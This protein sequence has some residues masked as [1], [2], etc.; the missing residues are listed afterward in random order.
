MA[1]M[2][3]LLRL[4]LCLGLILN[5]SVYAAASTQMQ[6]N[7]LHTAVAAA[8]AAAA[9]AAELPPCHEGMS[10]AGM[11]HGAPPAAPAGHDGHAPD[12]CQTSTC[13]CDCLQ[14]APVAAAGVAVLGSEIGHASIAPPRLAGHAPPA[15]PYPIRPPIG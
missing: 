13:T 4:L 2:A 6:L 10:M 12:C 14:P 3:I 9:A 15:L 7:H 5:G 1:A 11:D 8:Q